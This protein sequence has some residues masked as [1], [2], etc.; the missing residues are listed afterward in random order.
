MH[1]LC[2]EGSISLR[3]E[4]SS[5]FVFYFHLFVGLQQCIIGGIEN[6]EEWNVLVMMWWPCFA[7]LLSFKYYYYYWRR[8]YKNFLLL[9]RA[10]HSCIFF[11]EWWREIRLERGLQ[12]YSIVTRLTARK[13]PNKDFAVLLLLFIENDRSNSVKKE[14][15]VSCIIFRTGRCLQ[16]H[17]W[18]CLS[19]CLF[20]NFEKW[21]YRV[22]HV[23]ST[24]SF[25]VYNPNCKSR[26][27]CLFIFVHEDIIILPNFYLIP[28]LSF[29]HYTHGST[30]RFCYKLYYYFDAA[31]CFDI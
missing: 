30:T 2:W 13:K 6:L 24:S 16:T 20:V 8:N 11:Y 26:S 29:I 1:L 5:C 21:I 17:T 15:K 28:L 3:I 22:S 27:Y 10:S 7:Q 25:H 18:F 4:S 9:L 12:R 19:F 14:N 23:F 31:G